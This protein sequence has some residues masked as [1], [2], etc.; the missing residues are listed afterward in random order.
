M[1]EQRYKLGKYL[2]ALVLIGALGR[3]LLLILLPHSSFAPSTDDSYVW[4]ARDIL[5]FN[6]HALG[7]RVPVYPLLVALCGLNLRAL[8]VAQSILGVMASLMIFDMA[9]RRTRQGLYSLFVGVVC[10]L[11]PEILEYE[12][13]VVTEVLTSFLLVTSLWLITR[14]E[15]AGKSNIGYPLA[16]G[17][18]VALAGLTRP[19]MMCLVPV[20]LCFLV[21]LWRPAKILQRENLRK[22]LGFALPVV[23]LILGWCG[24]NYLNHGYF[25]PTTRAGQQ[26][27]DQV[28]PYVYLAPDRFGVLRDAWLQARQQTKDDSN[29]LPLDTFAAA[30]PE[31]ERQTGKTEIQLSQELASLAVYLAIRHPFL[32]LRRVEQGWVQFWGEPDPKE[33]DWPP[34]GKVGLIESVGAMSKFVLREI[35]AAFLV[36][37]LLSIPC[38]LFR[39]KAFTRIEYLIFTMAL[40]VSIFAAFTEFG[41]NRRFC[42]P[43][44]ML[45]V[46]TVLTRGWIWITATSVQ[47]PA[48]TS[49]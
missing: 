12:A 24:F 45:I 1:P 15:D 36:L 37:A 39:P 13:G 17:S 23:V 10:S 34:S 32:W 16:L 8:W 5:H 25:S 9:F 11:I 48:F 14:C 20:Y 42:V 31:M 30:L 33:V 3:L 41:D 7:D 27:M 26:L 29:H 44:Y 43:F 49:E 47:G 38:A 2:A 6:F 40:W 46:Y 19:L 22:A 28:D 21:P 4:A 18:I 35:K